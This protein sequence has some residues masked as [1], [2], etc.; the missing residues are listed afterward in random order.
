MSCQGI[1]VGFDE[2]TKANGC[3]WGVPGSHQQPP[4]HYMKVKTDQAT[5]RRSTFMDPPTPSFD[6]STD[7]AVPLETAP[8]SI[9]L[10]HGSFLHFSEKNVSSEKQRHAYTL[11]I[12]E[13]QGV[14]YSDANW[15]QRPAHL[16]FRP[17]SKEGI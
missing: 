17:V 12:V 14:K 16:P 2:A 6:Y 13:S 11:H 7:G 3:L 4:K 10:I 8:G 5:G 9:V 15:I 1:W